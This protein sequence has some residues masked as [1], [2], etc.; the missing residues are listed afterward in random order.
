MLHNQI[1]LCIFIHYSTKNT[2]PYNAEVFINELS[3]HFDKIMVLTN[4]SKIKHS[5]FIDNNN[6]DIAFVGNKGYDFGKFYEY[7]QSEN[8]ENFSEI[9]IVNDSNVLINKLDK[10]IYEGRS[11][12]VDFWGGIDSYEKP[13][14]STHENNYHIQSHFLIL[15]KNALR[16]LPEFLNTIKI[17]ELYKETDSKKLRRKVINIW[18]IGLSQF[19]LSKAMLAGSFIST[20]K[21]HNIKNIKK[22]NLAHSN[23]EE[24]IKKGYPFLKKKVACTKKSWLKKTDN[25]WKRVILRHGNTDWNLQQIIKELA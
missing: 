5:I 17:E 20:R 23:Y 1:K 12:G 6:I 8:L 25:N 14:F 13:W 10:F 11:K 7:I 9:A 18:E 16:F 19:M 24:L 2:L 4:N 15:F 3:R 22:L 21:Y